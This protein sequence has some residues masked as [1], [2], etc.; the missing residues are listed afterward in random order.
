[1]SAD[2]K[3]NAAR[4]LSEELRDRMDLRPDQFTLAWWKQQFDELR[5]V[6]AG[7]THTINM[8]VANERDFWKELK[9]QRQVNERLRKELEETKAEVGKLQSEL[10]GLRSRFER[11]ADW[12]NSQRDTDKNGSI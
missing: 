12:A 8:A 7:A 2:E 11:V 5:Q 6:L 4:T 1:M 9:T 10:T 3:E